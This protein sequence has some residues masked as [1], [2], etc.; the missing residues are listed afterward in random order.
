[1]QQ[2][3]NKNSRRFSDRPISDFEKANDRYCHI[4]DISYEDSLAGTNS[5]D[6]SYE[7]G[8]LSAGQTHANADVS[9]DRSAEK[10]RRSAEKHSDKDED[11]D[12]ALH[13]CPPPR[14]YH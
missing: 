14:F 7:G 8:P 11:S 6:I 3:P 2:K 9:A 12:N 1:M 5:A 4:P 10:A 13:R